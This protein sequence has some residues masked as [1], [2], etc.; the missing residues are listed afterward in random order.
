[1]A[2]KILLTKGKPAAVHKPAPRP[3]LPLPVHKLPGVLPGRAGLLPQPSWSQRVKT[4][5]PPCLPCCPAEFS[6]ASEPGVLELPASTMRQLQEVSWPALQAEHA[7]C[8]QL[9]RCFPRLDALAGP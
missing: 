4:V 5:T 3:A 1:M 8:P 7:V 9:S 6:D 2:C